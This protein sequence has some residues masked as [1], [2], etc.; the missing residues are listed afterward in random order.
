VLWPQNRTGES[1]KKHGAKLPGS[2]VPATSTKWH[3]NSPFRHESDDNNVRRKKAE[4]IIGEM[5]AR[6]CRENVVAYPCR[7]EV[8]EDRAEA[9]VVKRAE[10]PEVLQQEQVEIH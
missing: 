10:L 2:R 1:A 5:T 8:E 4:K 3:K 9:A 7:H 6:P